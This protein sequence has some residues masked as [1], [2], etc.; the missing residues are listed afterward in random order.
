MSLYTFTKSI[1]AGAYLVPLLLAIALGMIPWTSPVWA[2][3]GPLV[4]LALL[5]L[6]GAILVWDLEHP[7]RFWMVLVQPAVAQ[8]AGARGLR[9]HGVRRG[10]GRS[11]RCGSGWAARLDP[12]LAW[13]G[14]PL[15]VDD[16]GLHGVSVCPGTRPRPVAEPAAATALPRA[17]AGGGLG[18]ADLA[19]LCVS[20]GALGLGVGAVWIFAGCLAGR[21]CALALGEATMTHPTAHAAL[22]AARH[23]SRPVRRAFY[24]SGVLLR[25]G[26]ADAP[27]HGRP[28]SALA[29]GLVGLLLYEH[30]YVQAG[31][32]V[33]LA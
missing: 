24:W 6:T 32:S 14:G 19:D 15:A 13:A 29:A 9:H 20:G 10:P 8:L 30:A 26:W 23:A 2:L 12:A 18:R 21:S 31:Q 33:P 22:A 16:G 17:G 5:V 1:A 28:T 7:E 25:R 4:A 27:R 3:V 11:P